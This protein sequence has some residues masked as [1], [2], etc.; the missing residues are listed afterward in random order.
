M[1]FIPRQ[2]DILF[3]SVPEGHGLMLALYIVTALF[4]VFMAIA[5]VFVYRRWRKKRTNSG[6]N[7]PDEEIPM[8]PV[9]VQQAET[10]S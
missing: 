4:V 6:Y 2:R 3:S 1:A 8:N 9:T 5:V 7:T 10:V